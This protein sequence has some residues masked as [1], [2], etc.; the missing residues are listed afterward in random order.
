MIGKCNTE[1][2]LQSKGEW[3]TRVWDIVNWSSIENLVFL[4]IFQK[5]NWGN[6]NEIVAR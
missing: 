4:N 6:D 3:A 5:E 1:S 2:L